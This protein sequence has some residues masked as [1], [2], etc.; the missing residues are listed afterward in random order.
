MFSILSKQK[1]MQSKLGFRLDQFYNI[2]VAIIILSIFILAFSA[3]QRPISKVQYQQ[4]VQFSAQASHPRTQK[5]AKDFL[6]QTQLHRMDY[7]KILNAY[8]F[9]SSGIKQYPAMAQE[10]E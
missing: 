1:L 6:E 8:Q 3:L 10:D 5:M 9:E 4:I 2:L 7:L